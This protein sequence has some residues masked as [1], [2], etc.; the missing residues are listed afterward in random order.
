MEKAQ[1]RSKDNPAF[2]F[3]NLTNTLRIG[4]CEE[5]GH[6]VIQMVSDGKWWCLHTRDYNSSDMHKHR[7]GDDE[8]IVEYVRHLRNLLNKMIL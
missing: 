1:R 8:D 2:E 3:Y 6:Q 7:E 4:I 5:T